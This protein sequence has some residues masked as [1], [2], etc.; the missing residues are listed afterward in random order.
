MKSKR[1]SH[2][3]ELR[4]QARTQAP[5]ERSGWIRRAPASISS[6]SV[7]AEARLAGGNGRE[8]ARKRCLIE[9]N[10]DNAARQTGHWLRCSSTVTRTGRDRTSST[11][12]EKSGFV[13]SHNIRHFQ[14]PIA[15]WRL[16]SSPY[17]PFTLLP[18]RKSA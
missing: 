14:L 13:S 1:N 11:Y 3:N 7:M 16:S 2:R 9:R 18:N 12:N 10:S 5:E 17:L 6:A 8:S 15:D 4:L